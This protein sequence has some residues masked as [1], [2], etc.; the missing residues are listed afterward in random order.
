VRSR[1]ATLFDGIHLV[2]GLGP[3]DLPS[4]AW[5]FEA[6]TWTDGVPGPLPPRYSQATAQGDGV[7]WVFGGTGTSDEDL[8]DLWRFS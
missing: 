2:G 6:G 7:I 1:A 3:D 4:D 8:G 5:R